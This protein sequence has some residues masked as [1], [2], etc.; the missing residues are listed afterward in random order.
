MIC[1][2]SSGGDSVRHDRTG[3]SAD[4]R[5]QSGVQ[6]RGMPRRGKADAHCGARPRSTPGVR[7]VSHA[8]ASDG[9]VAV[10]VLAARDHPG[11]AST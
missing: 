10:G 2:A 11:I 1:F 9:L 8:V 5:M 3:S 7:P 6:L 4:R